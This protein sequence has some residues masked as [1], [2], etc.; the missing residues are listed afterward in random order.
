MMILSPSTMWLTGRMAGSA[1]WVNTTRPRDVLPSSRRDSSRVSA[2]SCLTSVVM[3]PPHVPPAEA[4]TVSRRGL[5]ATRDQGPGKS[6]G[7]PP[8]GF[9]PR[10]CAPRGPMV[11]AGRAQC[12]W[13]SAARRGRL[14]VE[15]Q[16]DYLGGSTGAIAREGLMTIR[17]GINGF[18]R[19]GRAF[20]RRTLERDDIEV[21]GATM[22]SDDLLKR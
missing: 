21:V 1:K 19:I 16:Q 12:L 3:A 10:A 2:S 18:G 6:T 13:R 4:P 8:R 14:L 5:S 11:P 22:D 7:G 20:V 15:P 9:G 17:V